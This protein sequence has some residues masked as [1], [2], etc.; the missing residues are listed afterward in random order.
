MSEEF[1]KPWMKK[2]N[3]DLI[4]RFW[5]YK[6]SPGRLTFESYGIKFVLVKTAFGEF[7]SIVR[8]ISS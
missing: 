5:R 3:T 7:C 6:G 1:I 8:G 2:C 4:I